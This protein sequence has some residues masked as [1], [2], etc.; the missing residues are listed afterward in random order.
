MPAQTG[1]IAQVLTRVTKIGAKP[2]SF[3]RGN[4]LVIFMRNRGERETLNYKRVQVSLQ[5]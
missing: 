3:S 1:R 2:G 4:F 5:M